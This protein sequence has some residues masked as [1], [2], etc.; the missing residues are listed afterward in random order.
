MTSL[1]RIAPAPILPVQS[2]AENPA[3]PQSRIEASIAERNEAL[4]AEFGNRQASY[5]SQL[6]EYQTMYAR[7]EQL[8]A[9]FKNKNRLESNP[10]TARYNSDQARQNH[11]DRNSAYNN[12]MMVMGNM[13]SLFLDASTL[14]IG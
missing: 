13:G 12:L 6:Q 5:E 14:G 11:F 3:N 4:R 9:E 10:L 1:P 2:V 8:E 7:F